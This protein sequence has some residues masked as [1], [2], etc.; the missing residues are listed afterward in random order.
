MPLSGERLILTEGQNACAKNGEL[1]IPGLTCAKP[2]SV[3]AIISSRWGPKPPPLSLPPHAESSLPSALKPNW[4]VAGRQP[5]HSCGGSRGLRDKP[6]YPP[7]PPPPW[8]IP[9]NYSSSRPGAAGGPRAD[10]RAARSSN[11]AFQPLPGKQPQPLLLHY[12]PEDDLLK[13]E[14]VQHPTSSIA[15]PINKPHPPI[16]S[17]LKGGCGGGER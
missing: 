14:A 8:S 4:G 2:A 13:E 7:E 9:E 10:T 15:K 11:R 5:G 12:S 17:S 3:C 1:L 6:V 16:Q